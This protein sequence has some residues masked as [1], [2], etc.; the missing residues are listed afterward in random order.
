VI[1]A[2][3]TLSERPERRRAIIVLS[4][5]ADTLSKTSQDKALRAALAANATVYTVDMAAIED[6]ARGGTISS[7]SS[8][9]RMERLKSIGA[10]KMFA[11]KSGGR[12]VPVAGGAALREAFSQIVAELSVQYTIGYQP[13]NTAKD[14]KWRAIEVKLGGARAAANQVRSRKGYNAPK[15]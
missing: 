10:L 2:A 13:A 12:F 6:A 14:G 5:G 9:K 1:E 4:D 3:K 11:E 7:G 8:N 15:K